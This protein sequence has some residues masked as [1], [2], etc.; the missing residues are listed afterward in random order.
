MPLPLIPIILGALAVG[1]ATGGVIK[2]T[3]AIKD[4]NKANDVNERAQDIFNSAKRKLENARTVTGKSLKTFGKKKV[5]CCASTV[6]TFLKLYNQIKNI[7]LAEGKL[8]EL[9]SSQIFTA[10]NPP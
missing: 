7:E 8:N 9:S 5:E 6:K 2:G 3:K 10:N 1:T 4:N